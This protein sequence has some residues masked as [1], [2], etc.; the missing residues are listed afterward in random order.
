MQ[1][2]NNDYYVEGSFFQS[3]ITKVGNFPMLAE[4]PECADSIPWDSDIHNVY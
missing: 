4:G 1:C 2:K 3:G